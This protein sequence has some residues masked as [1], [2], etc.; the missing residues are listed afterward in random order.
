[1]NKTAPTSS[2]HSDLT[3]V[4]GIKENS[5]ESYIIKAWDSFKK[6]FN[7]F[8]ARMPSEEELITYFRHLRNERNSSATMWTT[9]VIL[10]F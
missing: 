7:M 5:C 9:F 3:A 4:E 6:Y 2:F 10:T 8:D 1:M